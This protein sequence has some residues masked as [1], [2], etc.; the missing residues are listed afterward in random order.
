MSR[1]MRSTIFIVPDDRYGA[2]ESL[3]DYAAVGVSIRP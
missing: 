1:L 2:L 3:S